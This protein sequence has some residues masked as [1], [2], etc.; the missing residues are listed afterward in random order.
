MS[1]ISERRIPQVDSWHHTNLYLDGIPPPMCHTPRGH[2]VGADVRRE[3][4]RTVV[5]PETFVFLDVV[6]LTKILKQWL[7]H[8]ESERRGGSAFLVNTRDTGIVLTKE[9]DID[10]WNRLKDEGVLE[11]ALARVMW[12]VLFEYVVPT[13]ASLGLTF[14]PEVDP[15][16]GLVVLLRLGT[17][18]PLSVG[19]GIDEFR[20]EHSSVLDAHWTFFCGVPL[21]AIEKVLTR[22]C[23]IGTVQTFWRFGVLVNGRLNGNDGSGSLF[24]VLEHSSGSNELD[25]K[26]YDDICTTAPWTARAYAISAVRIITVDFPGLRSRASLKCPEH[27]HITRMTITVRLRCGVSIV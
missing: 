14:P 15:A 10:S 20:S 16:E 22:C 26:V 18:R 3:F 23:R 17:D 21:G 5:G 9:E 7:N 11:P 24:L 13:L 1:I 2:H 6:W 19:E 4:D 25:M 27:K 12:P 8:K